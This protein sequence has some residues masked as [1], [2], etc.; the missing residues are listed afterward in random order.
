[1]SL[2]QLTQLSVKTWEMESKRLTSL[3]R[4]LPQ[5]SLRKEFVMVETNEIAEQNIIT[6]K[7]GEYSFFDNFTKKYGIAWSYEEKKNNILP[8][9][10]SYVGYITTPIRTLSL[11]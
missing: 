7:D 4:R 5:N 9:S 10:K 1:M 2:L 3:R 11:K 8:L 6:I